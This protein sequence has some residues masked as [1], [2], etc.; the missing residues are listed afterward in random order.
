MPFTNNVGEHAVRKPKVK[1]KISGCFCKFA[2][3]E[4][5]CVIRLCLDTLR[6][7]GHCML[8]VLQSTFAGNPIA[9]NA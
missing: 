6:K 4:H 9:L 7:Q 2:G 5:F 8:N 3:A 1:Q